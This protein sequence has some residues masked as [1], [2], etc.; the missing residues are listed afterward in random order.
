M[1]NDPFYRNIQNPV[2]RSQLL[3]ANAEKVIE[4]LK[5]YSVN[6]GENFGEDSY[7]EVLEYAN[8]INLLIKEVTELQS[9]D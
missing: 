1:K 2:E 9:V 3:L 7:L 4:N 5:K 8:Q 6:R